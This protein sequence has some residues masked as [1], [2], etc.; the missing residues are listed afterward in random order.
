[1]RRSLLVLALVAAGCAS[2][3]DQPAAQSAVTV[4]LPTGG[5]ITAVDGERQR[6][7]IAQL[8]GY[9]PEAAGLF[10][11]YDLNGSN[12]SSRRDPDGAIV[13]TNTYVAV[14]YNPA[15]HTPYSTRLTLAITDLIDAPSEA[16]TLQRQFAD[17]T[18]FGAGGDEVF[19]DVTV[20]GLPAQTIA[21]GALGP[22]VRMLIAD[23][24]LVNLQQIGGPLDAV[25]MSDLVDFIEA[26]ALPRL[27][28]APGYAEAGDPA[29][30]EWAAADV[31]A[32]EAMEAESERRRE[33]EEA[34]PAITALMPC[35]QI[36]SATEAAR[37]LGVASVD[38]RPT[39]G[40]EVEGRTCNRAY[41][42]A[43]VDGAVLMLISHY[44]SS[45]T[46]EAAL[47]VA[48]DHDGK[49][50]IQ[51]LAGSLNGIRY[52]HDLESDTHV[53]HFVVGTDF[54]ELKATAGGARVPAITPSQLAE[55]TAVVAR[56]LGE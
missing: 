48:S 56:N 41:K 43:G 33:A 55:V 3:A 31:A 11:R 50:D 4:D 39:P 10:V 46:A 27:S 34:E 26:S 1:M 32:N 53:S 24:F 47:R 8:L 42:P 20:A 28:D 29:V 19:E 16:E 54:V 51:P 17:Q 13:E 52:T 25:E 7:S 15:E 23:R 2:D 5:P 6:L 35:N 36:L 40:V 49:V 18:F 44:T 9:V 22:R 12:E 37:A 21:G 30:P 45:E 38:I 14:D